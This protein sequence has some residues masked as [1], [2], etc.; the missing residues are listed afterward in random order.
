MRTPAG[1]ECRHYYQDFHRGHNIQECRLSKENPDSARWRPEDCARCT[2]P[3]I[4][5][6]NASPNLML[7][8]TVKTGLL[9]FGRRNLVTATCLKHRVSIEDPYIGCS[10]CNAERPGMDVFRRALEDADN[11]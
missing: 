1:K 3:D 4:L 7:T 5:N 9:G 8:L 2:I 11:D 6:A 10:Q